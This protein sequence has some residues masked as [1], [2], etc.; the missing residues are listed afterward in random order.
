MMAM[1]RFTRKG[2]SAY[3]PVLFFC[4]ARRIWRRRRAGGVSAV[5]LRCLSAIDAVVED[6]C[7]RPVTQCRR[8]LKAG[9]ASAQNQLSLVKMVLTILPADDGKI[10][11]NKTLAMGAVLQSIFLFR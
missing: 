8:K 9:D 5:C 3:R 7:G 4:I 6:T 11:K 1:A 2:S 10:S